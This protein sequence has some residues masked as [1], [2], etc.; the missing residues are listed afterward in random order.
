MGDCICCCIIVSI[1]DKFISYSKELNKLISRFSSYRVVTLPTTMRCMIDKLKHDER[2]VKFV[3]S[4]GI[5]LNTNGTAMFMSIA[6][7][8]LAHLSGVT[9]GFDSL[10][11]VLITSTALSM[12]MPSIPSA[13]LVML[14]VILDSIDVDPSNL[15]L[16][17]GI[18]WIL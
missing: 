3:L 9:L 8:F 12:A 11:I 4:L 16:L 17:F 14:L 13:S 2:I 7:V 5:Y 1:I 18:D 10:F 6:S 15:S